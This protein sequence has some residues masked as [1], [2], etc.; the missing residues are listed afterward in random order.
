MFCCVA[1]VVWA[2]APKPEPA[3]HAMPA[4][5]KDLAGCWKSKET[6]GYYLLF[7]PQRARVLTQGRLQFFRVK[8]EP[9]KVL[10]KAHGQTSAATFEIDG[11]VLTLKNDQAEVFTR[12][13]KPPDALEL[14]PWPLGEAGKVPLARVKALQEDFQARQK[15]DQA[16]RTDPARRGEMGKVDAENTAYLKKLIGEIGWIDA[17][18]FGAQASD[19]AF[20]IVQHSGDLPLM[21]AAIGPIEKDVKA[22]RLDGQNYALL[23][24]RLKLYMGEKQ[25]YGSQIGQDATGAPVVLPLED[26]ARVEAFRREIGIFPLSQYLAMFKQMNGG[27]DVKFQADDE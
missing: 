27:K 17:T 9:G 24:D 21:M 5:A 20:L 10:F 7:E 1:S 26:R 16:V 11:G 22:G 3:A 2:E 13:A 12:E 6:D 19:A 4:S 8:Y 25:K 14:K 23:Y 18:R 15:E